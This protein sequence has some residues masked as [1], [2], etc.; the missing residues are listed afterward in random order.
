MIASRTAR[1]ERPIG[2][3]RAIRILTLL[4]GLVAATVLPGAASGSAA[5]DNAW[6][7]YGQSAA[8][9]N[10][11]PA[12]QSLTPKNIPAL[13]TAWT[14]H[15]GDVTNNGTG[16]V[17]AGGFTY[18]GGSD[19]VLSA[20]KAGGCGAAT[21]EALWRARTPNGDDF[22]GTP[23]VAGKV[24]LAAA[25]DHVVYAFPAAGCGKATCGP[26]WTASTAD[27]AEIFAVA[28]GVA[29]IGDFGGRL[30]AFAVAGCGKPT[31]TPLWTWQGSGEQITTAPAVGGGSVF[32]G[33]TQN[34]ADPPS[35]RL[36]VLAAAGCGALVCQPIWTADL[37]GPVRSFSP[38]VSGDTVFAGSDARFGVGDDPKP[39]LFAF[40][41]RGCGAKVCK[42]LRSYDLG[43]TSSGGTP[44]VA[45][46]TLFVRTHSSPVGGFGVVL[47]FPAA[48]CGAAVCQPIWTGM[49][50]SEGEESDPVVVGHMVLVAASPV[51]R[52]DDLSTTGG[53]FA[54]STTPCG[55]PS[56]EPVAFLDLQTNGINYVGEPLAVANGQVMMITEDAS[57][58]SLVY[59]LTV[60]H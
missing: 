59:V 12:E 56:C 25:T 51:I 55:T 4:L 58:R 2:T 44:A 26:V 17:T 37:Q 34:D 5:V 8:H 33:T 20:F 40:P 35:G 27:T 15:F 19:G 49:A 43:D 7:Q 47:A 1:T 50:Q 41:A 48:G 52:P 32:V 10:T 42:P 18:V 14:D 22:P 13:K 53:I 21:C 31:C 3:A 38:V 45:D 23:A 46:G 24:V 36:V 60:P 16:P 11:N 30:Y 9:L 29:Y 57:E 39:Q 6:P 28:N 54:Y